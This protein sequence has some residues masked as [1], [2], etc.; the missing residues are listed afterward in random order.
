MR[1]TTRPALLLLLLA[2][3]VGPAAASDDLEPDKAEPDYTVINLPTTLRL[4]KHALA[5]RL[6]HRFARPLGRGDF[7]DLASDLFGFDGGAQIGIELRFAPFAGSQLGVYRTSDRTIELFLKQSVLQEKAGRPLSVAVTA[8]LEGLDNLRE[9]RSPSLGLVLSK[10]L[11]DH[12]ALYA[13]PAYVG[14]TNLRPEDAAKDDGTL[15]LGL[16]GRLVFGRGVGLL[17]EVWPR[18]AGYDGGQNGAPLV[19]F[20]IEKQVGGH[21]F[22][23]NFSNDLG[24]TPAQVARGRTGPDD[25]FIGFNLT[26]KF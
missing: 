26:R 14:H 22:Q 16:G 1:H 4:P 12:G 10:R 20:G 15:V 23:I 8:S 18:L 21:A 25:W 11:G 6:T 5:F 9:E 17:A 7:S 3:L 24:T 13:V 2:G 19:T